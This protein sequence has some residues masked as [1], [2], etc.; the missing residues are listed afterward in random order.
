VHSK[1]YIIILS[2]PQNQNNAAK[3]IKVYRQLQWPGSEK[4][5]QQA[6]CRLI[7]RTT[8]VRIQSGIWEWHII[9]FGT[10]CIK[11]WGKKCWHILLH[12]CN[13]IFEGFISICMFLFFTCE[14]QVISQTS[15]ILSLVQLQEVR[16][17]KVTHGNTFFMVLPIHQIQK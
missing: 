9:N 4:W 10:I 16:P 14:E 2:L 15:H 7:P 17:I 3:L 13:G 8:S 6:K 1:T 12:Y 11:M 5:L